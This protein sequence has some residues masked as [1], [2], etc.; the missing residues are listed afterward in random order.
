MMLEG[1]K[2]RV[3]PEILDKYQ[4]ICS[5]VR[6]MDPT[7]E[8]ILWFHD[9]WNDP[10]NRHLQNPENHKLFKKFVFV[11]YY[12]YATYLTAF[13]LK[14]SQCA[15]LKNA[16]EPI[17]G[18]IL[19]PT[20]KINLIYHTTPHRG[21]ELLYPAFDYLSNKY[22]NLHLDIYS[23]FAIYGWGQRDAE[24]KELIDLCKKHPN[25]TYHGARPNEEVREKLKE[26]HIFAFPS[27]WPET[28]CIAAIEAM[29]AGCLVVAPD[30]AALPETLLGQGWL[31]RY[32]ED[33]QRHLNLFTTY[34]NHAIVNVNKIDS[35]AIK[36][37]ADPN[38]NWDFRIKQWEELFESLK[39]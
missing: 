19:K 14:P 22:D 8:K 6:D 21:L 18:P 2:K 12:Q 26:A 25:I 32:D 9:V 28:S 15:V 24:Y 11:S 36:S 20:N 13:N 34:L 4:I 7:K 23:S 3:S 33:K 38:Y 30:Y 35:I 16:I 5:R 31:Y 1:L 39:D 29:S 10:E 27:I 17:E 37:Y